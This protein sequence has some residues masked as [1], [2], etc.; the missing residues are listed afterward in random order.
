MTAGDIA[1]ILSRTRALSS[2]AMRAAWNGS[3]R[4]AARNLLEGSRSVGA[5]LSFALQDQQP[6]ALLLAQAECLHGV[7]L[8]RLPIGC[9][10]GPDL[11]QPGC[12]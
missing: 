5:L 8:R 3:A 4:L 10:H 7:S 2:R 9:R 1:G 12:A 11:L 6:P